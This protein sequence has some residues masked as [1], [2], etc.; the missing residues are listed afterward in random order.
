MALDLRD[1]IGQGGYTIRTQRSERARHRD[2]LRGR[3]HKHHAFPQYLGGPYD[4]ALTNLP[5]DLHYLYHQ[6]LDRVAGLPRRAGKAAYRR[7]SGPQ[8]LGV[9][10]RLVRAT[11]SFDRQYNTHLLP[12]LRSSIRSARP[13]KNRTWPRISVARNR[14]TEKSARKKSSMVRILPVRRKKVELEMMGEGFNPQPP[15]PVTLTLS[16]FAFASATLSSAHRQSINRLANRITGQMPALSQTTCIYIEIEGHE[17]EV[18]DPARFGETG[19]KRAAAAARSLAKRLQSLMQRMPEESLRRVEIQISSAGP[20]RPVRSNV[21]PAGRTLNRRVEIR[22][23][24][25]FCRDYV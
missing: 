17:D 12:A 7:M 16:R 18:G 3:P 13:L 21:T 2:P 9:L 14:E 24:Q 8:M 10:K 15:G 5:P 19:L 6:I 22:I 11:G 1:W 25:A 23:R 4:G 20:V